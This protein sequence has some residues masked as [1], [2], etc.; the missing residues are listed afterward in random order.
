M[1]K[2]EKIPA[3]NLTKV[4]NKMEVIAEARNKGITVQF[5]PL[6]DL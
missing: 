2:N 6:V 5:S 4:R 3:W 1:A